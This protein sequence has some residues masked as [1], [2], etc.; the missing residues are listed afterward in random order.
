MWL[1]MIIS[2]NEPKN[3]KIVKYEMSNQNDASNI[4]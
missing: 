3:N 1:E 4:V 2:D